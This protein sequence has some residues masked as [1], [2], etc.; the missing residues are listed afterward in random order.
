LG[1]RFSRVSRRTA[2]RS[3]GVDPQFVAALKR[4]SRDQLH[5]IVLEQ[6]SG[7]ALTLEAVAQVAKGCTVPPEGK[8]TPNDVRNFVLKVRRGQ[9]EELV[10]RQLAN[11]AVGLDDDGSV[12]SLID[13]PT[14]AAS[15][16]P[17]DVVLSAFKAVDP[18]GKGSVGLDDFLKAM[19]QPGIMPSG[20]EPLDEDQLAAMFQTVD[21]KG[22]GYIQYRPFAERWVAE[23]PSLAPRRV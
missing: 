1:K 23:G 15:A 18:K 7:G 19:S 12:V 4:L 17:V 16:N 10:L 8:R 11:D 6:V 3:T 20:K 2:R 9:L 5:A 21:S 14:P 22:D 13:A